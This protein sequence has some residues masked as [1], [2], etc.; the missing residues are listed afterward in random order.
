MGSHDLTH[1]TIARNGGIPRIPVQENPTRAKRRGKKLLTAK[2]LCRR[3]PAG[4]AGCNHV[5]NDP[6]DISLLRRIVVRPGMVAGDSKCPA[7]LAPPQLLEELGRVG[8]VAFGI[9]HFTNRP[10]LLVMPVMVD[11]HAAQV[12]HLGA[13]T[14]LLLI[15]R[16]SG[17]KV[18]RKD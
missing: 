9:K 7:L 13:A 4:K 11:L 1:A 18:A 17:V 2:A 15:V 16:N 14:T 8:N 12:D 3:R 10:E 6:A 5:A